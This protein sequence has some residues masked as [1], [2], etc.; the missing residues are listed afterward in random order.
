MSEEKMPA[1]EAATSDE[2]M[3]NSYELAYHVLPTV[4]EGEV[5]T[6]RD[7]ILK[8][9]EDAGGTVTVEET[10]QRFDLAYEIVKYLE[11]KNRRFSS[12]YFGWIRFTA[13][14]EVAPVVDEAL[15]QENK[16]L[17]HL[18]IKLTKQ[19]EDSP[20][21]FHEALQQEQQVTTVE[22][23]EVDI[24]PN[25]STEEEVDTQDVSDDTEVTVATSE[26]ST[27]DKAGEDEEAT[28]QV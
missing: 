4:A 11:G 18:L 6:V 8:Q 17:R 21:F 16:V 3:F 13:T 19:E 20:F 22:E 28:K 10:P 9:I 12:A 15:K 1:T 26:S 27:T 14:S 24:D 2:Q 7:T 23:E 25:K 5:A